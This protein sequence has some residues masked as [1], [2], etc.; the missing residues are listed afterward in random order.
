MN[1]RVVFLK[2]F[3]NCSPVSV[4]TQINACNLRV[5]ESALVHAKVLAVHKCVCWHMWTAVAEMRTL[6][7][8]HGPVT[9]IYSDKHYGML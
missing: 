7:R 9:S 2:R 5:W 4:C 8:Q 3:L 1:V 6:N